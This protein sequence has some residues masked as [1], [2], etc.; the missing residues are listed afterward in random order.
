MAGQPSS[1]GRSRALPQAL[2]QPRAVAVIEAGIEVARQVLKLG[3]AAAVEQVIRGTA[4]SVALGAA[5]ADGCERAVCLIRHRKCGRMYGSH[6]GWMQVE[7]ACSAHWH[8]MDAMARTARGWRALVNRGVGGSTRRPTSAVP[9]RVEKP[10]TSSSCRP[11][12]Q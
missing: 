1:S 7:P 11:P 3:E 6:S 2:L 9:C 8:H 12:N 4:D 10:L 5:G